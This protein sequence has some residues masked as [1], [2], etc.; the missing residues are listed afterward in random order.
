[1]ST[2]MAIAGVTAVLRHRLNEG[3]LDHNIS[4][5]LGNAVSVSVLTPDRLAE[6]SSPEE[7]S[8]LNLFL[9]QVTPNTGWRN[10]RSPARDD[11]SMQH[12]SNPPLA[13][14]LHYLISAC[15]SGDLHAEILLGSAVQQLHASPV[16]TREMIR[17]ALNPSP[18]VGLA[19]PPALRALAQCG[20]ADQME[21]LRISP[22]YLNTEEMSNLW[23]AIQSS[24]RL[25]VAYQVSV[26]LIEAT[27][28]DI[29]PDPT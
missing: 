6:K 21:S 15:S 19:L 22:H 8:R 9:Y 20:L 10:A 12:Q 28:P 2:A 14:D 24:Y 27:Q 3:L 29:T 11:T 16:L 23:M 1:M 18:D 5:M 25:S 7:C 13:L 4:G 17:S 26:V